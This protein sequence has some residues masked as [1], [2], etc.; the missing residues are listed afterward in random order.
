MPK[1][2]EVTDVRERTRMK[3]GGTKEKYV[4]ITIQTLHGGLGTVEI[5]TSEYDQETVQEELEAKAEQL[6]M[7]FSL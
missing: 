7:P 4:E 6:E 2:Y 5:L 3:A 1:L